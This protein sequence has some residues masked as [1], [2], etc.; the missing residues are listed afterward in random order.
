MASIDR[1][2]YPTLAADYGKKALQRDFT[3][4]EDEIDW[5]KS[6]G[7]SASSRLGLCMLLKSFQ[8]L[9]YFVDIEDI[10]KRP[11]ITA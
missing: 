2:A 3:V 8:V 10:R 4:T 5:V 9:H 11:V 1:T 6:L 7:Q